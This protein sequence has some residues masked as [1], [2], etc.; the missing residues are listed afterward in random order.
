MSSPSPHTNPNAMPQA[1]NGHTEGASID[2]S[3]HRRK[4]RRNSVGWNA[5]IIAGNA[6]VVAAHRY[7]LRSKPGSRNRDRVCRRPN[8]NGSS[9]KHT[10]TVLS[11]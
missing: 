8:P 3:Q 1:T 2:R 7:D 6:D 9:A 5:D 10:E 11:A 4:L